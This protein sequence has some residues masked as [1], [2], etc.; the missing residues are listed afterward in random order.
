V[1]LAVGGTATFTATGL[2]LYGTAGPI[3]NTATVVTPMYD[4]A[5]GNNVSTVNTPVNTDLIFKDGCQ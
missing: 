1:N 2:V 4:T 3:A 5:P